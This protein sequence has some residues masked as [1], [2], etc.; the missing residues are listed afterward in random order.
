MIAYIEARGLEHSTDSTNAS[1]DYARNKVRLE[2]GP[3]LD[4]AFPGWRRGVELAARKAALEEAALSKACETLLFRVVGAGRMRRASSDAGRLLT[5]PDALAA[6]AIVDAE[7]KVLGR[8][9]ASSRL[10]LAALDS[11]RRGA[12][13]K[14]GGLFFARE[15]ELVVISRSLDFPRHGGYFV[16]IDGPCSV[17]AK[18]LAV[19]ASWVAIDDPRSVQGIRADAFSFPLVVRSRLP[20]DEL[21]LPGGTKRLDVLLSEMGLAPSAR[22]RIPIVEDRV[23]IVAALGSVFGLRNRYRRGPEFEGGRRLV[24]NVKGA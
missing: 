6:R 21:A 8:G 17:R 22:D 16:V 5:A 2:L 7:G 11:L 20:G 13:Y 9:R 10:A 14:G 18:S 3:Y 15:G 12:E 24:I 1:T 4:R 19:S 23:G